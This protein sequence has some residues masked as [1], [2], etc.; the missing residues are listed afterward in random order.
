MK[1][2]INGEVGKSL[3][4]GDVVFTITELHGTKQFR[5]EIVT[6]NGIYV[7]RME[8]DHHSNGNGRVAS[9]VGDGEE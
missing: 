4:V 2:V 6:P 5:V 9:S 8:P 3:Y 1:I 7:G